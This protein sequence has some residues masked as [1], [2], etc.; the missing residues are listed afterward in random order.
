[1]KAHNRIRGA[2]WQLGIITGSLALCVCLGAVVA[3]GDAG[4][5]AS[6]PGEDAPQTDG[7]RRVLRVRGDMHYP[8]YEFLDHGQPAG[9]TVDMIRAVARIMGLEIAI[10]LGPWSEVRAQLEAGE[11]DIITGMLHSEER[12]RQVEFSESH[13][14]VTHSVFVRQESP[15]RSLSDLAKA[16]IVVQEGDIM[17]DYALQHLPGARLVLVASQDQALRQL[18]SGRHDAALLSTLQ[19]LYHA[20]LYGLSNVK[21]IDE[22]LAPLD[23]C[24]AVR[25]GDHDLLARL[26]EGLAIANRTGQYGEIYH[27]W[28][29]HYHT[30]GWSEKWARW[31]LAGLLM[32]SALLILALVW[33]LALRRQVAWRTEEI[34]RELAD[35]LR[36]EKAL[37]QSEQRY[38][39]LVENANSVILRM[40][41]QGHLTFINRFAEQFFGYSREEILGRNVLGT[42]VPPSDSEG[43]NLECMIR[44][45]AAHPERYAQNENENMRKDGTRVWVSWTNRLLCDEQQR[46][47]EILCIGQDVTDRKRAEEEKRKLQDQLLQSQKLESVGRL[48]GGVAHDFNN[49]LQ[50]I[51]GFADLA[52]MDVE[53]NHPV[54]E[55]LSEIQKAARRSAELTRQLLAFAR[56]Q[57]ASPQPLDLNATVSGMLNML[58]RLIGEQI[59]LVWRPG[60][61]LWLARMDP[62]QIDQILAN[63]AVNARDAIRGVGQLVIATE[64]VVMQGG[65]VV[66]A[67]D[68]APGEYVVL[69]VSD[70]G[71]GMDRETLD[72]IFEPF[73]TTKEL[74][75]GTGLGLAMIYGIVLQNGGFID[76]QSAPGQGSTFRIYLPRLAAGSAPETEATDEAL[77]PRRGSE[78][79]LLVED[80]EVI[81]TMGQR[82]LESLGYIVLTAPLPSQAI[83]LVEQHGDGIDLLIT[84]VIMPE[85]NGR[86]LFH[87]IQGIVP[88]IKVLYMS[89]YTADVIAE[90]DIQEGAVRFLQKPFTIRRLAAST[91]Q[92]LDQ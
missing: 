39:D 89:G 64:N 40:D 70:S 11:I 61:D 85:M 24:F 67:G 75:E 92:A 81:L 36:A 37:T 14:R 52:M 9:F 2:R 55:C 90:Q 45:I 43:R 74:G 21:I 78:T 69:S 1:M 44:D 62:S 3:R 56:R 47:H 27:R 87:R 26:N 65:E 49:M 60:K 12:A 23:Y 46:A 77:V 83:A 29:G 63:L 4:L 71:V 80:E 42:I 32:A 53:G 50:T 8:P 54:Q 19:G 6:L 33:S 20:E 31:M 91:R 79:I 58:G 51:I 13:V 76:V 25:K 16:E 41:P 5:Q 15:A 68:V 17:H 7:A 73:F 84:D 38:R 22:P 10:E 82:A 28:F 34:R 59:E 48:A 88:D 57:T 86:E 72:R 66:L 35:R 30:E 18:A